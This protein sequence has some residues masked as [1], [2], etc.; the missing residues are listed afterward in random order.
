[1]SNDK[2]YDCLSDYWHGRKVTVVRDA[3]SVDIQQNQKNASG[4]VVPVATPAAPAS[5]AP[6]TETAAKK[7]S[8]IAAADIITL[9]EIR[10]YLSKGEAPAQVLSFL[11]DTR[12]NRQFTTRFLSNSKIQGNPGRSTKN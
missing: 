7:A 2:D 12:R 1:M 5:V 9:E 11:T 4:P 6:S 3:Y 8:K 10:K